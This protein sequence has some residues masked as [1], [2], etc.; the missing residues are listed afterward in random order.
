[1]WPYP[2]FFYRE[3]RPLG[4]KMT[5]IFHQALLNFT[6]QILFETV[7]D[8]LADTLR[9]SPLSRV[10][11]RLCEKTVWSDYPFS[12]QAALTLQVPPADQ[13]RQIH[14][15][16]PRDLLWSNPTDCFV[17]SSY[18]S[19]HRA[20]AYSASSARTSSSIHTMEALPA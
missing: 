7:G 5:L 12:A 16:G 14:P 1:M 4:K 8:I 6:V 13:T 11:S 2:N 20:F 9:G 18:P 3:T 17:L 10:F 15:H 19:D